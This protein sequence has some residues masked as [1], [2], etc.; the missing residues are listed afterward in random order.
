MRRS[1]RG[2]AGRRIIDV[3]LHELAERKGY[4]AERA[5]T[6][7]RWRLVGLDRKVVIKP[8][9]TAAFTTEQARAQLEALPDARE[10]DR[11]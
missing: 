5:I 7:G 6:P 8:D 4:N 9:R 10:S 3:E 2:G 1:R 11:G